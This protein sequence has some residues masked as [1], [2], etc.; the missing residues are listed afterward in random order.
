MSDKALLKEVLTIFDSVWLG[1]YFNRVKLRLKC[2]LQVSVVLFNIVTPFSQ[3]SMKGNTKIYILLAEVPG[4]A[5]DQ[6]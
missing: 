4:V 5:R 1:L 6:M 2:V 3:I